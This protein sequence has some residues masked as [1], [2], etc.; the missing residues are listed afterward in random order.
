MKKQVDKQHYN[1]QYY[2]THRRWNSYY[3][4][5]NE[6]MK[7]SGKNVLYIG[8]GDNIV[9]DTLKK[10]GKD[11]KT[12]DFANDLNPDYYGSVTEINKVLGEDKRNFDVI[13]CSQVLEHIPFNQ[14]EETIKKISMCTKEKFIL[15][16]PNHARWAKFRLP[17]VHE[18]KIKIKYLFEQKWDIN[19]QGHGEHYWEIDAAGCP[20]A[21]DIKNICIRYFDL[22]R[23]Y[24][25]FDNTYHVFFV[26]KNKK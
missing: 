24:I 26:L 25:P 9:V 17:I 7:C 2:I 6:A 13:I 8:A 4:Q 5:L 20:T 12:L 15:S 16:L 19:K 11:V 1:F 21:K 22:E 18:F 23:Y 10:F 14:F 3:C